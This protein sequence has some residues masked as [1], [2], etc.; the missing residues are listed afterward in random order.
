[1]VR[2]S[3]IGPERPEER[4]VSVFKKKKKKTALGRTL[5]FGMWGL[6]PRGFNVSMSGRGRQKDSVLLQ[7]VSPGVVPFQEV[8]I[9]LPWTDT[10][11][12]YVR[13]NLDGNIIIT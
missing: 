10:E 6:G 9:V 13:Y 4:D 3:R 5:E 11:A 2:D 12:R 1:M 8:I 7:L